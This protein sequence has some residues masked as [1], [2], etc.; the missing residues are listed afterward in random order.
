LC[1]EHANQIASKLRFDFVD[2]GLS[3]AEPIK[4]CIRVNGEWI[5]LQGAFSA[6]QNSPASSSLTENNPR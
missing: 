1:K 3:L 6:F 5:G 2:V 4:T